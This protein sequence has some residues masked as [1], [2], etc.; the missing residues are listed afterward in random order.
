MKKWYLCNL[1]FITIVKVIYSAVSGLLLL[2]RFGYKAFLLACSLPSAVLL[3]GRSFWRFESPKY[4]VA[5]GKFK[6]AEELLM[7]IAKINGSSQYENHHFE[8]TVPS[9]KP[10]IPKS[11][12]KGNWPLISLASI[13][14]FCQTSAYYGLTLW[15]SLFLDSWGVTPSLMLLMLGLAEIPG[16]IVTSLLIKR[17]SNAHR[18][19]LAMNFGI[20]AG[21]SL[22]IFLVSD[23]KCFVL[24]FCCLY[25]CIVSIWTIL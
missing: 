12:F 3:V 16:L 15:M 10:S 20:S 1:F 18:F 11:G 17:Y 23:T 13:T 22:L 25:F 6:E 21:L 7:R 4:L 2:E 8:L 14:F 9:E 24:A 5:K 19:L